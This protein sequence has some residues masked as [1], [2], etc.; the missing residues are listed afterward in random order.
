M[1][2]DPARVRDVFLS[3]AAV[4]DAQRA[5]HLDCACGPDCELR[6]EVERLLAAH[7]D[8]ASV[9]E[10]PLPTLPSTDSHAP[11]LEAGTLLAG[12]YKLLAE[13]GAGGMGTV[14]VAQQTEP[15]KRSVAVK[16]IRAGM[17]SR[18]V[19]ARFE[20]ERQALAL[21]DHPNIAKVLDGGLHDGRPFFVLE[22][23]RGVPITEYCDHHKLTPRARLELFVPVCQAIQHAHQKGIIHRDIKP[24]N[25]LVALYDDRPVV[26]VIDFG[27]AKATGGALTER[28]LDTGFGAVVGTPEYMSPEQA[29]FNNLDIDT[30]SDVYALGVLLYELLAGSPPF[31]KKELG[32][33]GLLEMLRVVRE[34][35]PPRPSTKL[36]TAGALATLSANRSTEPRKLTGLLRNELDWIVMK[37]LEKDRTR[38]YETANG[39]A[40]DVQRYLAGEPVLAHPPSTAY[41]LKKFVRRHKGQVIAASLVL[42]ALLGGIVGT[43]LGLFEARQQEHEARKLEQIARDETVEKE[44]AR[45]ALAQ[46]V[47]E[48]DDA[49]KREFER[50]QER[51]GAL[52]REFDRGQER[53]R[54]NDELE[55]RLGVSN[56]LLATAAYDN[57]D[58]ALAAERLDSVPVEQRGWEWHY[59]KRLMSGGIFTL[60]GHT[61]PVTC[62]ALS[63]DGTRI[64]TAAARQ[65]LPF[66][67]KIW[68]ART[69][70]LLLDLKGRAPGRTGVRLFERIGLDPG[71]TGS[72][73]PTAFSA[74][75][76]R[77]VTIGPDTTA[78]VWD[79]TTGALHLELKEH[80]GP[81][82][83]AVFSP[84]GTQIATACT[85]GNTGRVKVWDART[86]KTLLE[87]KPQ[88]PTVTR[89]AYSP[90]GTRIVTGDHNSA[91]RVWDA[92]TGAPLVALKEHSRLLRNRGPSVAV[93]SL[94]FSPDGKRIVVGRNDGTATVSDV[95]TGSVLAELRERPRV[96]SPYSR[97]TVLCVAFS[98]DGTRI[99]TGGS[100]NGQLDTGEATVWDAGTGQE[101]LELK[102][103]TGMVMS[104]AFSPDGA[105]I[106]TGGYDK[107]AKVWEVPSAR[108]E[109][110]VQTGGPPPELNA[111]APNAPCAAF[112]SDGAR[113]VVGG[114]RP[115]VWDVRTRTALVEL[116]EPRDFG[117]SLALSKDGTRV[118]TGGQ[119]SG[120]VGGH[121]TVWDA[122][123]GMI[124]A[125]LKG[126]Q[127]TPRSMAFSPDGT[128][129]VIAGAGADELKVCDAATGV[130]L[131]DLPLKDA[132]PA[133]VPKNGAVLPPILAAGQEGGSVAFSPDGARF[134]T[135]GISA[136]KGIPGSGVYVW[137]AR[138]GKVLVQM[139]TNGDNDAV[140]SVSYSKD[141]TRIVTGGIGR[142]ATLWNA[143]TGEALLELKGHTDAVSSAAF[144]PDATRVVT[145]SLDGTVRVWDE[146]TGT[147][148]VELRGDSNPVNEVSFSPD[149]TRIVSASRGTP[150]KPGR[151]FL[152]E[153]P[154]RTHPVEPGGQPGEDERAYRRVH[155]RPNPARYWTGYVTAR[156]A[157]D[158]FAT[159]F[160]L[161]LLSPDQRLQ[162]LTE[163]LNVNKATRG[164]EDPATIEAADAL[165]Q[166]YYEMG[167][168]ENAIPLLESVLKYRN[169]K[170]GR[171]DRQT[172]NAMGSLGAAYR[173]AGR[174]P[175]AIAVLA[176]GAAK[177]AGVMRNLLDA[178]AL[179]GEHAKVIDTALE[180]LAVVRKSMPVDGLQQADLLA[181]LGRAY[182]A[183][184]KWSEAE[185]HLREYA[186][187]REGYQPDTWMIFD[188]H[189]VLGESLLGQ[190]KDAEAEPLLVKGYEGLKQRANSIPPQEAL[191]L[192][193][194]LDRLIELYTATKKP[195]EV[196]KWRAE[197]AK[198]PNI[199]PPPRE[200]R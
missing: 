147:T 104:A 64:A 186:G 27:V 200:K 132:L 109:G 100:T 87:L 156:A 56:I 53:D 82:T 195:E 150:Y 62:V 25:V 77:V 133:Q 19:L 142:T 28:T 60:S 51:D 39:F 47:R 136:N 118:V 99:V 74:D 127:S 149:G 167:R 85:A 192:P 134:V 96:K 89:L 76:K 8:P 148:L 17:D 182:L 66:E 181:R 1:A 124:L 198:Y 18:Q 9:L 188:A 110:F 166:F 93:N 141:G 115:T 22:L 179:A 38:R 23:V 57:H 194:A 117:T 34:E 171:D 102:G 33:K 155:T 121:A 119:R 199:A 154:I 138:T 86:G 59:L 125:E 48:R 6:A 55:H 12:R 61:L 43:T 113:L 191:R 103:H 177:D 183:Q 92:R 123:T 4:P 83:H 178:Y 139:K 173:D 135:G 111:L 159:A 80:P 172:L 44:K 94:A 185:P 70:A 67:V 108:P 197:R 46:R 151:V 30:R 40:A 114:I 120:E 2:V 11:Q 98:P 3:A 144:N 116:K 189:S 31:S 153:A 131:L 190:N 54:A 69:G 129:I 130:V 73:T 193:E 160:Y 13:L 75:S 112:S 137:D 26:K 97:S 35:E 68:D 29:T 152:W 164:P 81:L 168:F 45:Q 175:E 37:A 165:G 126:F 169:A 16:L 32:K 36:S 58:P 50:G 158:N 176:E 71:A 84:D 170:L 184:K 128:R 49:L 24:S 163:A 90:D 72:G 122:R 145:G 157:G 65:G 180:R 79:A 10:P 52:K 95:Q 91:V 42:L 88:Y 20:V 146:R 174:L 107:T 161:K 187:L 101:L 63:P 196:K 105:R 5:A 21:M 143:Q 106:V 14:W 15:V 162:L 140:L 41:R 7:A 78:R